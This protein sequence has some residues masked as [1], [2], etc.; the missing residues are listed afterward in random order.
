M[1]KVNDL[2]GM[3]FNKL[4]VIER[5]ENNKYNRAQW[6]C[7][8]DCGNIIVVS[9]NAILESNTKSCGCLKGETDRKSKNKTH[10]MSETRL[11]RCWTAMKARCRDKH[12]KAYK[13]YG[14]RGIKVCDEWEHDF[15]AF[16]NW[17]M[18]NGYRDDLT[19][20]RKDVN[21]NYCPENCRWI[22]KKEQASN[23]RTNRY[24]EHNGETKTIAEWAK[25]AGVERSV[26]RGRI[27]RGWTM[28]KAMSTPNGSTWSNR[29]KITYNGET[30]TIPEWAKI[31]GINESTLR[32]R[33][34]RRGWTTEKALTTPVE[35]HNKK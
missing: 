33:L 9:G 15:M 23:K 20:D 16:Y 6:L 24:I 25:I 32:D 22:T 10:G 17:S 19:I 11:F 29:K 4:T 26:L 5:A 35:I 27:D 30:H 31:I 1:S 12:L 28:E 21:G 2:T 8:C 7:R 14:G 13:D 18:A 3:K 34:T